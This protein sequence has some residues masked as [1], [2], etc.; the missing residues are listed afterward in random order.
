MSW[1]T[2]PNDALLTKADVQQGITDNALYV[3]GS[4]P[5]IGD[6]DYITASEFRSWVQTYTFPASNSFICKNDLSGYLITLPY[7][8]TIYTDIS[9][10]GWSSSAAACS[11]T[12]SYPRTVYASTSTITVGTV[13]YELISGSYYVYQTESNNWI[14][15][16]TYFSIRLTGT[17][18]A[19]VLACSHVISWSYTKASGASSRTFIIYEDATPVIS[20]TDTNSGS[21]AIS[22]GS[23]IRIVMTTGGLEGATNSVTISGGASYGASTLDPYPDPNIDSGNLS[24]SG[25]VSIVG[26]VT[27]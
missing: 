8:Y 4:A 21:F 15:N 3:H 18:V 19:E 10:Q 9:N 24:V 25:N 7:S 1:G 26:A 6:D 27:I 20:I 16:S 23:T 14:Y 12:R 5:S 13:F 11:G 22:P 2:I 17:T